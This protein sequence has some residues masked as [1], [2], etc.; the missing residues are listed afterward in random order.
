MPKRVQ[1][2]RKKGWRMPPH[3]KSVAR[4]THFGNPFPSAGE[5]EAWLTQTAKGRRMLADARRE[6]RGY[7]LA[8]WCPLP[9]PGFPDSCHAAVL[10]RLVNEGDAD[11][12]AT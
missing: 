1:L 7:H 10:L 6:L 8:C 3:T 4:P 2:S 12:K 11:G 9:E 5:Y